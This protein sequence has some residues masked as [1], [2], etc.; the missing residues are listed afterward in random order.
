MFSWASLWLPWDI[1]STGEKREGSQQAINGGLI[2]LP[3]VATLCFI[4]SF[5]IGLGMRE[6]DRNI[7]YLVFF[8]LS[9]D[10][11]FHV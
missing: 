11:P 2:Y 6:L 1:I 9:S 5:D 8:S 7:M 10:R 4:A 3:I